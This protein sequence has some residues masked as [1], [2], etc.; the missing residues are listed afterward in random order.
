MDNL[1]LSSQT[2][3]YHSKVYATDGI[4]LTGK[5]PIPRVFTRVVPLW[6][7]Q[8]PSRVDITCCS[9]VSAGAKTEP[10]TYYRVLSMT[11]ACRMLLLKS[12]NS[13]AAQPIHDYLRR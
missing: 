7:V 9:L 6:L 10:L 4:L 8:R 5:L 11:P 12:S 1:T 13:C 2:L 3:M